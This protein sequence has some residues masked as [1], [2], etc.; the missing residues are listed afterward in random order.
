MKAR[1]ARFV[2]QPGHPWAAPH[3]RCL[4]HEARKR[5]PEQLRA[6]P[7]VLAE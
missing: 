7:A 5:C 1:R 3:R 4:L 6:V 2:A